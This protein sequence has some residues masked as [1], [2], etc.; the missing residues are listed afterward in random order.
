MPRAGLL[1]LVGRLAVGTGAAADA[2]AAAAA[3]GTPLLEAAAAGGPA[4]QLAVTPAPG[5][6][7]YLQLVYQQPE[8]QAAGFALQPPP[9]WLQ[10]GAAPAALSDA[11]RQGLLEVAAG[12]GKAA[13]AKLQ[14]AARALQQL[15]AGGQEASPQVAAAVCQQLAEAGEWEL[16]LALLQARLLPSLAPCPGL[17]PALAQHHRYEDLS[18]IATQGCELPAGPLVEALQHLLVPAASQEGK[19]AQE[20]YSGGVR[21]AAEAAVAAAEAAQPGSDAWGAAVAVAKCAAAVVDGF[22]AR[23]VCLHPLLSTFIDTVEVQAALRRLDNRQVRVWGIGG[24]A[25][26]AAC[27]TRPLAAPTAAAQG[28]PAA[29]RRALCCCAAPL[30]AGAAAAGLPGQVA[31]QVHRAAGR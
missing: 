3:G 20:R 21:A 1:S 16:L 2:D 7:D 23:E 18:L 30:R 14:Q 6:L 4:S 28:G 5:A 24:A 8:E 26:P 10:L 13:L 12:G 27:C 19:Q 31:G 11:Q 17:L 22:T 15:A 9:A 29:E 25:A